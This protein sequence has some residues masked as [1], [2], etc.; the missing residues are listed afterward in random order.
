[1]CLHDHLWALTQKLLCNICHVGVVMRNY[2]ACFCL[3]V[4]G[5]KI[6]QPAEQR[7]HHLVLRLV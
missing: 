4:G 3:A 5:N 7:M 1:M 6:A 2:C